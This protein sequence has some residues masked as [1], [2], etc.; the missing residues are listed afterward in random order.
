[1]STASNSIQESQW[2]RKRSAYN[3]PGTKRSL[4]VSRTCLSFRYDKP[5]PDPQASDGIPPPPTLNRQK[6]KQH[7]NSKTLLP[8]A[9]PEQ[10]LCIRSRPLPLCHCRRPQG[11]QTRQR[12]PYRRPN[13]RGYVTVTQTQI[14][15]KRKSKEEPSVNADNS[16]LSPPAGIKAKVENTTQYDEYV[17][18]LESIRSELGVELREAMFPE[19]S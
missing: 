9:Q 18:E 5:P 3:S 19:A 11:R 8:T 1:M 12:F 17:Q 15:R 10:R 6:K 13:L 16:L 2:L 4:K 14:Q 7:S